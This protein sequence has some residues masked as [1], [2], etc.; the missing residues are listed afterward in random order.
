MK[1]TKRQTGWFEYQLIELRGQLVK[2]IEEV[3]T[4]IGEI[5]L[6]LQFEGRIAQ[7]TFISAGIGGGVRVELQYPN[8]EIKIVDLSDETLSHA[9]LLAI[10]S[11]IELWM[12]RNEGIED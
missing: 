11:E 9:E 2:A 7:E 5:R 8:G 4:P 1:Q 3:L 6:G 12:D 10:L